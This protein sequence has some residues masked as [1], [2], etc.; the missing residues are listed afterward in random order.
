MRKGSPKCCVVSG[1]ESF[2]IWYH[3]FYFYFE[4]DSYIRFWNILQFMYGISSFSCPRFV[5]NQWLVSLLQSVQVVCYWRVQ[6]CSA[7]SV[8]NSENFDGCVDWSSSYSEFSF[9]LSFLSSSFLSMLY[10]FDCIVV[11]QVP[12]GVTPWTK[13]HPSDILSSDSIE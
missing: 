13:D 4:E 7:Y 2:W 11:T 8:L 9:F 12:K 10:V 5:P 6:H 1:L 3:N